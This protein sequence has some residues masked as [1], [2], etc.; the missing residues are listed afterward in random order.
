MRRTALVFPG[1]GSQ[2]TG[3]GKELYEQYPIAKKTFEEADQALGFDLT[4]LCFE[5][6][7]DQLQQT[8]YTQ[9]AILTYS[10]AAYRVF[11]Q[12]EGIRPH[13][14]AGHSL[15]EITALT[16]SGAIPFADAVR[17]VNKRGRFMQESAAIGTGAMS[18]IS[19]VSAIE[20]ER[21]CREVSTEEELVAVS[22]Y[23]SPT[24]TVISGHVGAV[25]AAERKLAGIGADFIRLKVSAPF[26]CPLMKPAAFQLEQELLKIDYAEPRIPIIAN[27]N[28]VPYAGANRIVQALTIQMTEP[29]QWDATMQFLKNQ[30]VNVVV[31][32]GPGTVLRNLMKKSSGDIY[33]YSYDK[34]E[35]RSGLRKLMFSEEL[36]YPCFVSRCL[37]IAVC[38]RN[39]NWNQEEYQ[40]G[41]IEPY[42]RIQTM[43]AEV[44]QNGHK[45]TLELK[46]A[47]LSMLQSVFTT[48]QTP[49]EEQ[50][51][52]FAQLFEE[53]NTRDLFPDAPANPLTSFVI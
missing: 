31:E 29:I 30:S 11:M 38:T 27:Y 26:H 51:E 32:L 22:N 19:R 39:R 45:P 13:F 14:M 5:G 40:T 15:G 28:A 12:E 18:A 50:Q 48:K 20:V 7:A 42:R 34:E 23:N 25:E 17:I 47:A 44:E 10:V 9:P 52:R 4:S 8:E 2:Y 36:E 24:Q 43:L 41:V 16:C 21:I 6:P 1:Q 35:D 37:A 46:Q 49:M 33:S 53:T 3:M